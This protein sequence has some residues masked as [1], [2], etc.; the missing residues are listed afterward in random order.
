MVVEIT[1]QEKDEHLKDKRAKFETF[2]QFPKGLSKYLIEEI[3]LQNLY[4][5]TK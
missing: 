3:G 4:F 2:D 5:A 1:Q